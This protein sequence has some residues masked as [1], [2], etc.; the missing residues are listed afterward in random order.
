MKTSLSHPFPGCVLM[1][2]IYQAPNWGATG[3]KSRSCPC[4]L[5]P[6]E[7]FLLC[8][9]GMYGLVLFTELASSVLDGQRPSVSGGVRREVGSF[10]SSLPLLGPS[11]SSWLSVG[12]QVLS[13]LHQLW[14]Q[15]AAPSQPWP[16]ISSHFNQSDSP[17]EINCFLPPVRQRAGGQGIKVMNA[18]PLPRA[19]YLTQDPNGNSLEEGPDFWAT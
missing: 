13:T 4:T 1:A 5:S 19:L 10:W 9:G 7:G 2:T 12:S 18:Y 16:P 14:P 15:S 6:C 11:G 3:V 8:L 17:G